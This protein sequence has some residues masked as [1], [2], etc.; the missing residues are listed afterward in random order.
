MAESRICENF[1][2]HF[3]V[4]FSLKLE[5]EGVK[6][7]LSVSTASACLSCPVN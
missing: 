7:D 6:I 2:K 4:V 1:F 3:V 5:K